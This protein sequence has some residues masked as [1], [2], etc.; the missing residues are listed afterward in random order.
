MLL[1]K[2]EHPQQFSITKQT[3]ASKFYWSKTHTTRDLI[4]IL[5]SLDALLAIENA[6]GT[7]A[8]FSEFATFIGDL[9]HVKIKEP[10]IQKD[11]I[12]DRKIKLT[13]FIDMMR[14][15]MIEKSQM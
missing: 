1:L 13:H 6:D 11:K 2:I 7:P 4:E 3:P 15:A 12:F 5:S 10:R 9:L 14:I 8:N